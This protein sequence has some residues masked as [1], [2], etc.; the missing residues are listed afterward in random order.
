M[1][2]NRRL[3]LSLALSALFSLTGSGAG[4][5]PITMTITLGGGAS[6]LVDTVAVTAPTS[7]SVDAAGL[8]AI[9]SFLSTNGSEY[10]LFG[11][12][13]SSNF[14]GTAT[15]GQLVVTGELHSVSSGGSDAVLTITERETSFT[16]P[17]GPGGTLMSSTSAN[18]TNQP[19]GG[20]HTALSMFNAT[21]TPTY[22]VLSTGV[23]VNP[24]VNG[25]PVSVGIAPVSTLYTLANV[26]RFGLSKPTGPNDIVDSF[27]VTATIGSIVP[28]PVSMVMFVTGM[29]LPLVVVGL[30]RRRRRAVA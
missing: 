23:A 25:G 17:T 4:A 30:L 24:G 6:F 16:S 10:Q 9:N 15:Q 5:S 14:P 1:L 12:S 22:S 21:S 19:A 8:A 2:K 27:G 20:G 28:E 13:G 3:L 11:L 29:P 18:F 26:A 7:Y